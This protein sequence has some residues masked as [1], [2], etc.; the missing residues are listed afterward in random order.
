M[1]RILL[2]LVILVVFLSSQ[3]SAKTFSIN[4]KTFLCEF[5]L[6]A[7]LMSDLDGLKTSKVDY[8]LLIHVN[9]AL[10]PYL[11][12]LKEALFRAT[13]KQISVRG[14]W[15]DLAFSIYYLIKDNRKASLYIALIALLFKKDVVIDYARRYNQSVSFESPGIIFLTLNGSFYNKEGRFECKTVGDCATLL[16]TML[17]RD[18]KDNSANKAAAIETIL[19]LLSKNPLAGIKKVYKEY[20]P[21]TYE[22]DP[23]GCM[24][25]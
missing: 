22:F 14:N 23:I 7:K 18:L 20:V 12:T 13:G 3:A 10:E 1:K 19:S 6:P 8:Y 25:K 5:Y 4:A 15:N 16:T 2:S 21:E 17:A 9:D 11:G 24:S